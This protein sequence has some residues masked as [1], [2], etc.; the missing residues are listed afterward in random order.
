[1]QDERAALEPVLDIHKLR[2]PA[3]DGDEQLS[4]DLT[5][6]L[7][8]DAPRLLGQLRHAADC[9]DVGRV[10]VGGTFA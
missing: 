2:S 10:K 8:E 1:M 9:N 5:G 7:L 4:V 3:L 6:F